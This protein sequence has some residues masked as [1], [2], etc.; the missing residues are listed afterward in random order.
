MFRFVEDVEDA[1]GCE[2]QRDNAAQLVALIE[3]L[4][5]AELAYDHELNQLVMALNE[6]CAPP[7]A[8]A[9]PV[10]DRGP[11]SDKQWRGDLGLLQS[12]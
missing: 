1:L 8:E 7:P 2:K 12:G 6:F 10:L 4:D 5:L 11:S 3:A 9:A